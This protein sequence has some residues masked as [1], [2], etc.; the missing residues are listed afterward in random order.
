MI[1]CLFYSAIC[2]RVNITVFV[3]QSAVSVNSYKE[4]RKGSSIKLL[5]GESG[6]TETTAE[7][8]TTAVA[9]GWMSPLPHPL[10]SDLH[11]I[12]SCNQKE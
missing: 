12:Y 8:L 7:E 1:K 10:L 9:A 5:G 6:Q 11:V 3:R 4:G 2:C